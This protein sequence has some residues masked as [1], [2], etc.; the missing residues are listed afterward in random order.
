MPFLMIKV[1]V[2]S[3]STHMTEIAISRHSN[4]G[5]SKILL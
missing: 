5:N 4:K 1:S 3:L 2:M